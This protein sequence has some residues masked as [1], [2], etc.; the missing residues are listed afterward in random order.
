MRIGP[1]WSIEGHSF[2]GDFLDRDSV[3]VDL[4]ANRGA[5]ATRV[6]RLSQAR[7]I[8][9]EPNP[10]LAQRLR[11]HDGIEVL[12]WAISSSSGSATFQISDNPEASAIDSVTMGRKTANVTVQTETLHSLFKHIGSPRFNLVKM[13]IEGAEV[14]A[15]L[16]AEASTLATIDQLTVEF[17]D[18]CG[19]YG[20]EEVR[21]V[22]R[23]LEQHGFRALKFSRSNMD[24]LFYNAQRLDVPPWKYAWAKGPGR[25]GVRLGRAIKAIAG[26]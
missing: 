3:V 11:Q 10:W 13:D 17:H 18:F 20:T 16:N 21:K 1:V 6:H 14:G 4:G 25:I 23:H 12:D 26:L 15:I 7:C 8:A 22:R 19:V 9:V 2:F 5:F 24:I